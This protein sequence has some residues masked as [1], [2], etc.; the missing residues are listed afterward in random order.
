MNIVVLCGGISTERE[1]SISSGTMVCKGLREYGHNAVLMDV[2]FG[3]DSL[4]VFEK[5]E[6]SY[7]VDAESAVIRSYSEK[8][9][10]E[11]KVRKRFFG[12][13]VLELCQEADI[14][15]MALHGKYGEDGLCQAAFDLNGIK[16]TGSGY[17]ASAIG[18]DKGATKQM[19]LAYGVPT[20]NSVWIKKGED[21]NLSIYEMEYPV[22]VKACNGGSSVGVYIV[23]NEE[24]YN[25][26]VKMCFELDDEILVEDYIK[27][28]EFSIGVLAGKA[29]P[30]V[31][32]IP[33]K[34]WY[35]YKNKYEAGAVDE[36]CPAK[37]S[38]E[39]TEKMQ[40]V[41]EQAC[42][43]LGCEPYSRADILM[44]D[45][46]NMFCLEVNTLPGMTPTSLIPREA[47]AIGI[48]FPMLCN[49]LV[50]LS[51]EKYQ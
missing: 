38:D 11:K 41:A 30:V 8:L 49:M 48:D 15:F 37:L 39:L 12:K 5:A 51:L 24:E 46:E 40:R 22:V 18:M 27:G 14:V 35:D 1:I 44:D 26:A 16:Y 7:D 23:N 43:S 34:G 2:Y 42:K 25:E 36:I 47:K 13:N 45:D 31:E 33:K 9:E 21:T 4:D 19:F 28:R 29:L 32:I 3:L 17:L 50:E 10:E 20:A 6:K